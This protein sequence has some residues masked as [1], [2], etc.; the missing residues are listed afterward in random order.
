MYTR[1]YKLILVAFIFLINGQLKAQ[2]PGCTALTFSV[3]LSAALDTSYALVNQVRGG[4]C[5]G[6][7]NCVKFI[8]VLN[9][10]ADLLNFNVTNPSPSGSA[11]YSVNCG[12]LTS[13]GTPVCVYGQTTVCITYCKPGGDS[14]TYHIIQTKTVKASNN[15]TVRVGCSATMTVT[16][17]SVSTITWTSVFPGT[18]G[19]YNS[20]LSC[21][22]GCTLTTVTPTVVVSPY[23]DYLVS[24]TPNTICGGVSKDTVRIYTVP[25]LTA[26]IT[27]TNAVICSGGT[28]S[29]VLTS[30]VSGGAPPYTYTWSTGVNTNTANLGVGTYSVFIKDTAFSCP[31]IT[32]T[33]V[34]TPVTTP[35]APTLS[36]NTP[37]C[38][39][40]TVSL[41]ATNSGG[42][43]WNWTGPSGF[44]ATAQNPT[45]PAAGTSAS[46]TY[47]ATMS[48]SG[49]TGPPG[50]TTVTVSNIP[51]APGT[52]G[53]TPLCAGSTISLTATFTA[54]AAYNWSGPNGFTSV[55]QNPTIAG[56][57]TAA[58]GVYSVAATI[59]GC[60]G[61]TGTVN[62]TVNPIPAAPTASNNSVLC[63]GQAL[64][65]TAGAGGTTYSWTGPNGFTS[66][67]QNPTIPAASTL[68]A[69]NYCHVNS[70]LSDIIFSA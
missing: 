51:A 38:V 24:G 39:G 26:N 12:S 32:R 42:I 5:C 33:V 44:T 55:L 36:N 20:F 70:K 54:G 25:G 49:C 64:N 68:A 40:Q 9:P 50:V 58:S 17:L 48:F 15:K 6:D 31:A 56:A 1:F 35:S 11:F 3:N 46:G 27:P 18:P 63:A 30:T 34:V 66:V 13:I 2:C 69:G 16:G 53:S 62:I 22:N 21:T 45:I 59:G 4:N 19:Q 7:N 60:Q 29:V 8:V 43:T 28:G 65:L 37:L 23:I 61:P 14:P 10:N 52:A 57:T 41:T 67:S 47:S